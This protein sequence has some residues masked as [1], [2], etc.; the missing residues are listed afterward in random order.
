MHQ[1]MQFTLSDSVRT[2][3]GHRAAQMNFHFPTH[4]KKG[5]GQYQ[6]PAVEPLIERYRGF[7]FHITQDINLSA[8]ILQ[9]AFQ[10]PIERKIQMR[11]TEI[12]QVI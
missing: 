3:S 12:E 6:N 5:L 11:K 9:T 8:Y 1:I 10:A 7:S 2:G 4:P